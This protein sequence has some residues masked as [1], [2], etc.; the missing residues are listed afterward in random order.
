MP[1]K[2]MRSAMRV[3]GRVLA[4]IVRREHGRD[5]LR[6]A[7]R[8][9]RSDIVGASARCALRKRRVAGRGGVREHRAF[10]LVDRRPDRTSR[11]LALR[12]RPTPRERKRLDHLRPAPRRRS[13]P[14]SPR[15]CRGR[16]A[17][18]CGRSGRRSRPAPAAA[19]RAWHASCGC[20]ARRHRSSR[21]RA[22][23]SARNRRS[24]DHGSARPAPC[25]LSSGRRFS[26]SSG[27]SAC[28]AHVG[29][30]VGVAKA[31]R[32]SMISMSIAGDPAPSAPAP[33]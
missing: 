31:V 8:L 2:R 28:S 6:D 9:Q 19:R 14:G 32:G 24:S 27:H 10:G 18:G 7:G 29:K 30:A 33:G 1:R 23:P 12:L 21:R 15:R 13:R 4:E 17:H 26:T 3:G 11:R 16:S 20:R 22:P 25:R 5:H